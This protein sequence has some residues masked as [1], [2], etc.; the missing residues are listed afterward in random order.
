LQQSA[1]DDDPSKYVTFEV[2]KSR[3]QGYLAFSLP[4]DIPLSTISNLSLQ[5]NFKDGIA[6]KQTW[7]IY[8][9]ST[10]GW[11]M[12]GEIRTTRRDN[13]WQ[14]LEFQVQDFSRYISPDHEIRIQLNSSEAKGD[15]KIDYEV[16]QVTHNAILPAP[17][18]IAPT[19]T[20]VVP[21]DTITP[22]PM[23]TETLPPQ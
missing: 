5:V 22:T 7:S 13:R 3:Y 11:V 8:D 23:P 18:L 17:V 16:I 10:K 12:L 1:T 19:Y 14:M 21:T 15:I 9:W 6:S 4:G 2:R 20:V